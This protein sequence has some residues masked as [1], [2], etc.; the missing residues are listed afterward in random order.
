M[1]TEGAFAYSL[2]REVPRPATPGA[3]RSPRGHINQP[4]LRLAAVG[5]PGALVVFCRIGGKSP[6]RSRFR[7]EEASTG[8]AIFFFVLSLLTVFSFSL[9]FLLLPFIPNPLSPPLLCS[10][11]RY[12]LVPSFFFLSF[13]LL[14]SHFFFISYHS[15]SVSFSLSSLSSFLRFFSLSTV[16]RSLNINTS[17]FIRAFLPSPGLLLL[18]LHLLVLPV[19]V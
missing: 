17:A 8:K 10:I 6:E 7:H 2:F 1:G 14:F 15:P 13:L 4:F 19:L 16:L 11:S 18:L 12:Y 5:A 3:L 9:P